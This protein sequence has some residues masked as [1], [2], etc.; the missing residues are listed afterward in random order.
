LPISGDLYIYGGIPS[1]EINFASG[2]ISGENVTGTIKN[3][4][5][6]KVLKI[7]DISGTNYG[8]LNN[9]ITPRNNLIFINKFTGILN[10]EES[11]NFYITTTGINFES[12]QN[13]FDVYINT[14]FGNINE[15]F[16]SVLINQ[17][18][19]FNFNEHFMFNNYDLNAN[20]KR[21]ICL[22]NYDSFDLRNSEKFYYEKPLYISLEYDSGYTGNVIAKIPASGYKNINLTGFLNGSGYL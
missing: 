6:N 2:F 10:P 22:L 13:V 16:D 4:S 1:Y 21:D 14:D 17:T 20:F 9:T 7:L 5:L 8:F 19:V 11:A 15:K 18:R 3:N 12:V